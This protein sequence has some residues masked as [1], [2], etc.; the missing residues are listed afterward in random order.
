MYTITGRDAQGK[1]IVCLEA[2]SY[3]GA[4]AE[5]EMIS[6]AEYLYPT[7]E[8]ITVEHD[9]DGFVSRTVILG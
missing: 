4:Q 6:Q 7:V 9:D 5:V 1:V 8:D 3:K 2:S